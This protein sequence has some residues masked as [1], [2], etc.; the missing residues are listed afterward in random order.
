MKRLV[1]ACILLLTVTAACIVGCMTVQHAVR[2]TAAVAVSAREQAQADDLAA[3][4]QILQSGQSDWTR[5]VRLLGAIVRHNE[6][7]QIDVLYRRAVQAGQNDDK[8]ELLLQ[9]SELDEMLRQ[10]ADM[11]LPTLG[12]VF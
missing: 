10:L 11:E 3:C 12:N 9:L 4:V 7:N 8:H 5:R 6:L 2:D 1:I